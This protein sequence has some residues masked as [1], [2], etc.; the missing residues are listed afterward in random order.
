MTEKADSQVSDLGEQRDRRAW[1]HWLDRRLSP[2]AIELALRG[3]K[4]PLRFRELEIDVSLIP[5]A[6]H[7]WIDLAGEGAS[8]IM[9]GRPGSGKT[10]TACWCLKELYLKRS[11]EGDAVPSGTILKCADLYDAVFKK[12]ETV[13]RKAET[14]DALVL[15]DW[16][17]G[18]EHEWPLSTVDQI[19]DRRWDNQRAT[20]ITSN[21]HPSEGVKSLRSQL[22]RAYDRLMDEDPGPGFVLLDRPSLRQQRP[23]G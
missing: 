5:E 3:Y 9:S 11:R 13:I 12:N 21:L 15:D 6:A 22:P 2:E 19:I 23:Q 16:G 1:Q 10:A 8:M 20:I 14:V 18:Y 7:R 17:S 4:I